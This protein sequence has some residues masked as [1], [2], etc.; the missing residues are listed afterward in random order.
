MRESLDFLRSLQICNHRAR[1]IAVGPLTAIVGLCEMPSGEPNCLQIH[2][3]NRP[4]QICGMLR[5]EGRGE[6]ATGRGGD[7]E[8]RRHGDTERHGE[9]AKGDT[10]TRRHGERAKGRLGDTATGGKELTCKSIKLLDTQHFSR[11]P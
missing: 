7:T 9:R 10:E 8:T 2:V 4:S 11:G 1:Q 5:G 6:G 3:K